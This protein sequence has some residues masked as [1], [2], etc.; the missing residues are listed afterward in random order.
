MATQEKYRYIEDQEGNKTL[1]DKMEGVVV[2]KEK[3]ERP[4]GFY[5]YYFTLDT[6]VQVGLPPD[7]VITFNTVEEGDNFSINPYKTDFPGQER[8]VPELRSIKVE[9]DGKHVS[10]FSVNVGFIFLV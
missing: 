7:G 1:P 2:G 4:E 9:R 3:I 6:G 10:A 8:T 5:E